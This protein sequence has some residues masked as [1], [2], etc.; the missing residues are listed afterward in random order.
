[1]KVY[2]NNL[3]GVVIE[4]NGGNNDFVGIELNLKTLRFYS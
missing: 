3:V 2:F 1:M 4:N